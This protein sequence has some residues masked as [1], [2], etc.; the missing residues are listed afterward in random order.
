MDHAIAQDVSRR[1]CTAEARI[2][3]RVISC[4]ICDERSGTGT[5]FLRV[6][7][8]SPA[9]YSTVAVHTHTS[10]ADEQQCHW[11]P[12][13]REI[14]SPYRHEQ[15]EP[16]FEKKYCQVTCAKIPEFLVLI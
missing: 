10:S 12:Q 16:F 13:F 6:F 5:G 14:I 8:S 4:G 3:S 7:W 9:A 1:F 2:F 11:S 15:D